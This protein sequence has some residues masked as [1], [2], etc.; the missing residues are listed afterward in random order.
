MLNYEPVFSKHATVV[1]LLA[2]I[3][4]ILFST[5]ITFF[6]GILLA[7]PFYGTGI[8]D[9]LA[10]SMDLTDSDEINL[11]KYLQMVSQLGIF[12]LPS[13]IFAWLSY[14]EIEKSLALHRIPTYQSLIMTIF[15]VFA[16]LPGIHVLIQFNESL[17][18][19]DFLQGI[20][21]WMQQ[22][23]N[24]AKRL[25]ESFLNTT[26]LDGLAINMLMIGIL[27]SIGEELLFRSVLIKL[28]L[29]WFKNKHVAVVLSAL[30]FSAFHLQFYG[31][32]PR[33]ALGLLFGYLFLWSGSVWLPI[34]AHFVNNGSAVVI[35]FLAK[36]N[37][38]DIEAGE[39]GAIDNLPII[40]MSFILTFTLS[41]GIF[42]REKQLSEQ[43]R[44]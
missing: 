23:E 14:G 4:I 20:E 12:V 36:K 10:G 7:V 16:M 1:K 43:V 22:K 24:E 39:F 41:I 11:M 2:L 17:Q 18:L 44:L 15:L 32:L 27:A 38:L 3:L 5:F 31:F 30:I 9:I 13:V 25:T 19:P 8:L 40:V 21:T 6:G 33:F 35:S 26:S 29:E 34:L 42:L 28:L 37:I